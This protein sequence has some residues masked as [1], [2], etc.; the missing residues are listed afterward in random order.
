MTI[1]ILSTVTR[2][3]FLDGIELTTSALSGGS[4]A[5]VARIHAQ[6]IADIFW[7]SH[8]W[9]K[10]LILNPGRMTNYSVDHGSN[11][12]PLLAR[13]GWCTPS[14]QTIPAIFPRSRETPPAESFLMK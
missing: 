2:D 9:Q 1:A 3:L 8:E 7:T 4:V 12:P 10:S 11:C 14:E 6:T 5:R 13:R